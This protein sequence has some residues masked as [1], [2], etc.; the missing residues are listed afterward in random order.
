MGHPLNDQLPV[1]R[2]PSHQPDP[3]ILEEARTSPGDEGIPKKGRRSG[4]TGGDS[5]WRT[6]PKTKIPGVKLEL[7]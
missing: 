6:G 1:R 5:G 7:L 4:E 2:L 3:E